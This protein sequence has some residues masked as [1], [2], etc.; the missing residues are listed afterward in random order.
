MKP[1]VIRSTPSQT[2]TFN[3]A[4]AFQQLPPGYQENLVLEPVPAYQLASKPAPTQ[5]SQREELMRIEP[6][7]LSEPPILKPRP[8]HANTPLVRP[9]PVR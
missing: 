7:P 8:L 1:S 9:A 5:E 4:P 2:S 3:S 6:I